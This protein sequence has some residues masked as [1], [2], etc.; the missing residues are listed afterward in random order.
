M[1]SHGS[2]EEVGDVAE[3]A[4]EHPSG[5]PVNNTE[6]ETGAIYIIYIDYIII[7]ISEIPP[8]TKIIE[9]KM[10][11]MYKN[12]PVNLM[13]GKYGY[14]L[15]HHSDTR[16]SLPSWS[17]GKDTSIQEAIKTIEWKKVSHNCFKTRV[18]HPRR[19][20]WKKNNPPCIKIPDHLKDSG[21]FRYKNA[22]ENDG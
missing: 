3:V 11:G 16:N 9:P 4:A 17:L 13:H 6:P 7:M 20:E 18:R 22:F 5:A 21:I 12:K 14:Y 10:L 19:Q 1:S 8:E 15:R 2:D